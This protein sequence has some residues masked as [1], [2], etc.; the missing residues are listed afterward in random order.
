MGDIK[1]MMPNRLGIYL[2]DTHDKTVFKK[3]ERWVSN[4]CVRLENAHRLA[5]W[6]FGAM[7]QGSNPDVE[8]RVDLRDPVPVFVTYL[9]VSA[10][11]D[12]VVFR[13]DRYGR[14]PAALA[15]YFGEELQL[16]AVRP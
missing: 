8:E 11:G 4:G 7:P 14:D 6:L 5:T 12:D 16:A 9:T 3:D 13:E 15:R 2:H 10:T 1:F